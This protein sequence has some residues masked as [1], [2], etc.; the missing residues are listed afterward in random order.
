MS[1]NKRKSN[2]NEIVESIISEKG[3][4]AIRP[5]IEKEVLHYD[6][7]FSLQTTGLLKDLVFQ[8]GT[9]LRL[10]HGS[11]RYSEDLDFAGGEDFSAK[12]VREIKECLEDYITNRYGFEINIKEP[13][14]VL[15]EKHREGINVDA[16]QVSIATS[17]IKNAKRQRIKMEIANINAYTNEFKTLRNNYS[18]LPDAYNEILINMETLNEIKADKLVSLPAVTEYIRNR[19]IW[20]LLWLLQRTDGIQEDLIKKKIEDYNVDNFEEKLSKLINSLQEIVHGKNFKDE[21]TRFLEPNSVEK[22]IN[23]HEFLD[24]LSS[25]VKNMFEETRNKLYNNNQELKFKI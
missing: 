22:F 3:N 7:L 24:Y 21:M 5:V 19:D 1:V 4:Q 11:S 20:D 13:K 6:I 16:W 14:S 15:E 2:F 23:N 8:G 9:S 18:V 10:C 17:P 25:E 12:Q